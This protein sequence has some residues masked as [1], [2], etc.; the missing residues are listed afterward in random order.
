MGALPHVAGHADR[1]CET[2]EP[3]NL[4]P[5]GVAA[6]TRRSLLCVYGRH[7]RTVIAGW[8]RTGNAHRAPSA[9]PTGIHVSRFRTIALSSAAVV[10]LG[11]GAVAFA[12]ASDAT[13]TNT[14]TA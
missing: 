3:S 10:A 14:I 4:T 8:R 5:T 6:I 2:V 9:R 11:G 12:T 7:L 1:P 13:P